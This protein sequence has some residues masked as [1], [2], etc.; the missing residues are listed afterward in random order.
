VAVVLLFYRHTIATAR[1]TATLLTLYF[2][3]NAL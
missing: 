1:A 3:C 2:H